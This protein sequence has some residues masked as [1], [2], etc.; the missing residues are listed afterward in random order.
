VRSTTSVLA[1]LLIV[2]LTGCGGGQDPAP[3]ARTSSGTVPTT[4]QRVYLATALG[5]SM[6]S[7]GVTFTPLEVS[8]PGYRVTVQPTQ[9]CKEQRI[10]NSYVYDVPMPASGTVRI[11]PGNQPPAQ[12]DAAVVTQNRAV[13]VFYAREGEGR[14]KVSQIEPGKSDEVAAAA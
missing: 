4:T 6:P 2:V 14:Y 10:F 5:C 7:E 9:R 13:T 1:A 12:V 3:S 11:T 8:G